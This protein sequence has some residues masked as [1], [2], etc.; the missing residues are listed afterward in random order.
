MEKLTREDAIKDQVQ[1]RDRWHAHFVRWV[2]ANYVLT[3]S[4]TALSALVAAK[5]KVLG[6]SADQ[7]DFAAFVVA[8]ATGLIAVLKPSDQADRIRRA[9]S[10]LS[11]TI[12]HR[13][14]AN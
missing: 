12:A 14:I 7:Y 3:I 6:L 11:V 5:P 9:W 2:W 4:A 10:V 1:M 8:V 13:A